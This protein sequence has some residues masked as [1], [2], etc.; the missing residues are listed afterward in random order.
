V[1][2]L[3]AGAT[4]AILLAL[5]ACGGTTSQPADDAE[6]ANAGASDEGAGSGEGSGAQ[7]CDLLSLSEVSDAVGTEATATLGSDE[8]QGQSACNYNDADGIPIAAFAVTTSDSPISPSAA[9]DA[10]SE[11]AEEVSGL[12]DRAQWRPEGTLYALSGDTLVAMTVISE[13]LD[14]EGKK[15]AATELVELILDRVD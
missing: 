10:V 9:F 7:A 5:V 3:R 4:A 11:G 8:L 13:D 12:G 6:T 2:H 1:K 14:G 15:Q